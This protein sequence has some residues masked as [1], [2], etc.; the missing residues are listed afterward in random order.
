MSEPIQMERGDRRDLLEVRFGQA[1]V[2][3]VG[4]IKGADAAGDRALDA[5]SRTIE[6]AELAVVCRWRSR[7]RASCSSR[8][9]TVRVRD[10]VVERV[11]YVRTGKARQSARANPT[12]IRFGLRPSARPSQ[13]TLVWPWGRVTI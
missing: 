12:W 2:A 8:G 7:K 9:R 1:T 4:Q 6:G 13:R 11:H 5:S 10:W 3:R